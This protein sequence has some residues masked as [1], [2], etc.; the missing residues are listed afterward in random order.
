VRGVDSTPNGP[1]VKSEL[2][3][4]VLRAEPR[5]SWLRGGAPLEEE[6]AA[7]LAEEPLGGREVGEE[8]TWVLLLGDLKAEEEGR[9][10]SRW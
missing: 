3:A 2:A 9:E 5:R 4:A 6:G 10:A 8:G 7:P 1:E